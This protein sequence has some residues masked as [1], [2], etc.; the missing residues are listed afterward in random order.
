MMSLPSVPLT[1]HH[2]EENLTVLVWLFQS[3][4]WSMLFF[5][6]RFPVLVGICL[7]F[8]GLLCLLSECLLPYYPI[9]FF[10]QYYAFCFLDFVFV[11][12]NR[13]IEIAAN[14]FPTYFDSDEKLLCMTR[15]IYLYRELTC[16]SVLKRYSF[17]EF[18]KEKT[19]LTGLSI[20]FFLYQSFV[21][22]NYFIWDL[23]MWIPAWSPTK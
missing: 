7:W 4:W 1:Q 14:R 23:F 10:L 8:R 16:C 3:N 11:F 17:P 5:L 9:L 21:K 12:F 6:K 18:K 13:L 2:W 22:S 19:I 15:S 20:N